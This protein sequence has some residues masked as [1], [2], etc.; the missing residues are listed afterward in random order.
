MLH[1]CLRSYRLAELRGICRRNPHHIVRL[2]RHAAGLA[3]SDP[4]RRGITLREMIEAI[5]EHEEAE[6]FSSGVLKAIAG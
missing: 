4:V 2:Y 3:P 1:D 5:I 6:S